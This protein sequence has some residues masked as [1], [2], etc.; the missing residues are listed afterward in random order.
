MKQEQRDRWLQRLRAAEKEDR[1]IAMTDFHVSLM[2][3]TKWRE[4]IASLQGLQTGG[5]RIKFVGDEKIWEEGHLWNPSPSYINGGSM[6]PFLSVAI[7]WL[8]IR[9]KRS[10]DFS[11]NTR[12][13]DELR[14][15]LQ[16]RQI[17]FQEGEDSFRVVGHARF[18]Q[19]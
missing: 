11:D 12:L 18:T 1:R 9:Y 14:S 4:L 5:F 2:N 10:S 15:R 17:P 8:E 19:L 3:N 16:A 13:R 6:G 7:E